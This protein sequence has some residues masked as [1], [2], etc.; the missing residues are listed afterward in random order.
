M[1][2]NVGEIIKSI[3]PL[4]P[5]SSLPFFEVSGNITKDNIEDYA[6]TGCNYISTSA[7]MTRVHNLDLSMQI[8]N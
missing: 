4:Y 7:C 8:L 6:K 3:L 2:Q 5:S 1:L